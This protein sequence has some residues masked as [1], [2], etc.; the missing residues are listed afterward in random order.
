[1][2]RLPVSAT[3]YAAVVRERDEARLAHRELFFER[4]RLKSEINDLRA[5]IATLTQPRAKDGRF[6]KVERS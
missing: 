2:I 3:R 4:L 5:Q 1:M 6:A